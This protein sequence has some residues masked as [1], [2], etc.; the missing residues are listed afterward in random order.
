MWDHLLPVSTVAVFPVGALMG[1]PLIFIQ[2][3]PN[4]SLKPFLCVRILLDRTLCRLCRHFLQRIDF[5]TT[6]WLCNFGPPPPAS[7]SHLR[8]IPSDLPLGLRSPTTCEE[9]PFQVHVS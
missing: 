3:V 7:T 1:S 6:Y 5:S 9:A 4:R 8:T 2:G